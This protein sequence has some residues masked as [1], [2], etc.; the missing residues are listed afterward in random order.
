MQNLSDQ[1][2][3]DLML[4][5]MRKAADMQEAA[6]AEFCQKE[7]SVEQATECWWGVFGARFRAAGGLPPK[8]ALE[9][10]TLALAAEEAQEKAESDFRAHCFL[11]LGVQH[12]M[13]I[14]EIQE[15]S[16]RCWWT[17]FGKRAEALLKSVENERK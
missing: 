14:K 6:E 11:H 1:E 16:M 5:V 8:G 2:L 12:G 15:L 10:T 7:P 3:R 17:V 9:R 13:D 4:E